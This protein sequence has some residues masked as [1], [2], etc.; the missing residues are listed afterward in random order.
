MLRG[1]GYIADLPSHQG[2]DLR[3]RPLVH[4]ELG[5]LT[6]EEIVGVARSKDWRHLC[7]GRPDQSSTEACVWFFLSNGV[8]LRGRVQ[9]AQGIGPRVERPSVLYGWAMTRYLDQEQDGVPVD[10]RQLVNIGCRPRNAFLAAQRH[11][12]VSEERWSFDPADMNVAPPMDNDIAAADALLTGYYAIGGDHAFDLM[13]S[14]LDRG[15]FPGFAI[16]AYENLFDHNG[17]STYDEP[18]GAQR[19]AHMLTCVAYR[20]DEICVWNSWSASWG[21]DGFAW[22]SRRLVESTFVKQRF[23]VTGAPASH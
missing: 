1:T 10:R 12:L 23:V 20:P 13:C 7:D 11:G 17:T 4:D 5:L 2:E 8:Y 19:G 6:R 16:D 15:H 21:D 18:R 9:E 22:F 3:T 14:A